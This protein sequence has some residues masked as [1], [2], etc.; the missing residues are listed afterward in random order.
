MNT[1]VYISTA[2]YKRGAFDMQCKYMY[3]NNLVY[4]HSTILEN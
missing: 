2:K 3:P 1:F 4:R